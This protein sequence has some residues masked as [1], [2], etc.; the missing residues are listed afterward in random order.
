[1]KPNKV[2]VF[3][4]FFTNLSAQTQINNDY[5]E[6]IV[7]K[8]YLIE[9]GNKTQYPYGIRSINTKGDINKARRIC[10]NTVKNNWGR[11]NNLSNTE[12]RKYHC[13]LD[14]LASR[15]CPKSADP[16]GHKNWVHNIHSVFNKSKEY[17][18]LENP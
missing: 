9:G 7:N 15:Y 13:F 3:F 6:L 18:H 17:R 12:K 14:F 2:L 16:I 5:L 10:E 8:I 4:V 1:M 11:F